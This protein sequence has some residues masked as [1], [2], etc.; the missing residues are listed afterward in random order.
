MIDNTSDLTSIR[1]QTAAYFEEKRNVPKVNF[2]KLKE[3]RDSILDEYRDAMNQVDFSDTDEIKRLTEL[4]KT[5]IEEFETNLLD[6]EIGHLFTIEERKNLI[7]GTKY[8][9]FAVYE[10]RQLPDLNNKIELIKDYF[11]EVQLLVEDR[12]RKKAQ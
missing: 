7:K 8:D 9:I 4:A 6:P 5:K 2:K 11:D 3:T 1:A 12:L 10:K